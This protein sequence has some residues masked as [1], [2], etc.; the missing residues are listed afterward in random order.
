M[1]SLPKPLAIMAWQEIDDFAKEKNMPFM[2]GAELWANEKARE[3]LLA[4][5]EELLDL[6]FGASG[7]ALLPEI[8]PIEDLDLLRKILHSIKQAESPQALR[9]HWSNG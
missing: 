6:R 9:R 7:L 1:M 4:G 3:C 2:T 8:R 5:I